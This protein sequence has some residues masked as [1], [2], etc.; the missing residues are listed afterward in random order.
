MRIRKANAP[1]DDRGLRRRCDDGPQSV[2]FV[3]ALMYYDPTHIEIALAHEFGAD[4]AVCFCL[5]IL[6]VS[7]EWSYDS[8]ARSGRLRLPI[9]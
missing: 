5:H 6:A 3:E 9:R 7:D 1:C 4:V 2:A 8:V